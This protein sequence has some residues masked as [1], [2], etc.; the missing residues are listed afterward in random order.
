MAWSD[1][2]VVRAQLLRNDIHFSEVVYRCS[3]GFPA[4]IK[5]F[6]GKNGKP[7]PT[8]YWLTCPHLRKEVAR[9]EEKGWIRKF[10]EMI[11]K[12]GDFKDRLFKAHEEI[13]KRRSEMIKDDS[14]RRLLGGVGS[15]GLRDFTKV[16]CL[17]L[18]L[19]DFLAGVDNPVGEK[20]WKM[21]EKKEC[22]DGVYC[23]KWLKDRKVLGR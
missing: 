6:P 21:I 12:D 7:F 3:F 8:L 13:I 15:G 22:D 9:L 1:I 23:R 19:A 20:V 10:E 11:Q 16:K 17:H 14:I 2:E 4:V 5:S 18:H